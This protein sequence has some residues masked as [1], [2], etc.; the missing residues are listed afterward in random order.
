ML[1]RRQFLG[2]GALAPLAAVGCRGAMPTLFG[3][4]FG[5]DALYDESISTVYVPTFQNRAFQTTPFRGFE[6]QLTQAVVNQIGAVT[7]YHIACD[8]DKADTELIGVVVSIGK[9]LYNRT[10]QNMVREGEMQVFVDV[11]WRDL[12]DGRILSA[13]PKQR[14]PGTP[15]PPAPGDPQ[16]IPFD[17]SVQVPPPS[18]EIA[19]VTPTRLFA[20]GRYLPELGET[21]SSAM[22]RVQKNLAVQIV[23]MMEKKWGC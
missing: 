21:N 19:G 1:S 13:P 8:P 17:P 3:Y 23:S 22:A 2:L 7:P 4:K 14:T 18:I 10:Q 11:V 9:Q 15:P 20:T 16:P 5:A 12:R 6:M